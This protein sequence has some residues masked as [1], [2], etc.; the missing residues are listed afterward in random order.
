MGA[1]SREETAFGTEIVWREELKTV[2][3]LKEVLKII[4]ETM[5]TVW[6]N[7]IC[8]LSLSS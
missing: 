1:D 6:D 8:P 5:W 2:V 3:K 4:L 7:K